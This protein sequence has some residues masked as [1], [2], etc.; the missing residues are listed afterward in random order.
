MSASRAWANW[1]EHGNNARNHEMTF[2][3]ENSMRPLG[4]ARLAQ[5]VEK[6]IPPRFGVGV[7][8]ESAYILRERCVGVKE[9]SAI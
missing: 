3:N 2:N 7:K 1:L 8:E 5:N 6:Y 4:A 9:E